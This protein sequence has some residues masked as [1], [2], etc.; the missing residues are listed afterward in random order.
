MLK[1]SSQTDALPGERRRKHT[2]FTAQD[3]GHSNDADATHF[4]LIL[5]RDASVKHIALC[6][7]AARNAKGNKLA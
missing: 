1:L 7:S 4:K 5:S 2:A 3:S 6:N